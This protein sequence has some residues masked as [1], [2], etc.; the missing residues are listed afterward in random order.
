[1]TPIL[2]A[3]TFLTS[4]LANLKNN[5]DQSEQE[6]AVEIKDTGI[7]I[8]K[9]FLPHIF[10]NFT[11]EQQGYSRSYDGNGLGLSLVKGYCEL[12]DIEISVKSVKHKG[13]CFKLLFNKTIS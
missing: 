7:G 3:C 4:V 13:T 8:S 11:Q 2:V 12:N 9:D 6:I 5:K 1:M 10:E